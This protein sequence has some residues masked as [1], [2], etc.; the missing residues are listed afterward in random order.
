MARDGPGPGAARAGA[1]AKA[2]QPRARRKVRRQ[3]EMPGE[4]VMDRR[5]AAPAVLFV[6]GGRVASPASPRA[7]AALRSDAAM[8]GFNTVG[9]RGRPA[10]GDGVEDTDDRRL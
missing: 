6:G 5:G 10:G 8:K 1:R 3:G 4:H 2:L 7:A 9:R